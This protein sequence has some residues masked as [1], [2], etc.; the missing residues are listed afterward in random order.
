MLV[1][2]RRQEI[3]G[4]PSVWAVETEVLEV[5]FGPFGGSEVETLAFVN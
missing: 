1:G 5:L 2:N 3:C 4:S